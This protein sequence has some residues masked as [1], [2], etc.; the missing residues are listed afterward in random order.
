MA[1]NWKR[2]H[3]ESDWTVY[4][5]KD[6]KTMLRAEKIGGWWMTHKSKWK[7]GSDDLGH[8]ETDDIYDKGTSHHKKRTDAERV[9]KKLM[10]K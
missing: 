8:W 7:I 5:D 2:K 1:K 10:E 4:I 6:V 3:Y 9:L